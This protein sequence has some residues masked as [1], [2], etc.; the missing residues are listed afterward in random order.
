MR[1]R[2]S[3]ADESGDISD[4]SAAGIAGVPYDG[5]SRTSDVSNASFDAVNPRHDGDEVGD[6]PVTM[7]NDPKDNSTGNDTGPGHRNDHT[8][9]TGDW[10]SDDHLANSAGPR[11]GGTAILDDHVN[12]TKRDRG[13]AGSGILNSL[14]SVHHD[15]LC[16]SSE[17]SSETDDAGGAGGFLNVARQQMGWADGESASMD[18][19]GV[20]PAGRHD[21]TKQESD[22]VPEV[23]ES[24]ATSKDGR[25]AFSL[26]CRL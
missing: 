14:N 25:C 16:V 21:T 20:F 24:D 6:L 22:Q 17:H 5:A 3:H 7:D 2:L 23:D 8:E 19:D 11:G 10:S 1:H 12:E 4:R 18:D 15:G 13:V 26:G 9:D